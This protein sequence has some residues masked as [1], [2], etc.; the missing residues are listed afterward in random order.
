MPENAKTVTPAGEMTVNGIE[1][2]VIA[3]AESMTN[4]PPVATET[5]TCSMVAGLGAS[6][7]E[8]VIANGSVT[9]TSTVRGKITREPRP[10]RPGSERV[11]L[12]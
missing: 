6:A 10:L 11:L 8:T 7:E 2:V 3:G 1:T 4:G 12:I 5:G 9:V